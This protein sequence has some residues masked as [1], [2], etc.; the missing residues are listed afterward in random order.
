MTFFLKAVFLLL[1]SHILKMLRTV[2]IINSYI[3]NPMKAYWFS[4]G[5]GYFVDFFF[6]FR[7]SDITRTFI[8]SRKTQTPWSLSL[9]LAI[10]ERIFDLVIILIILFFFHIKSPINLCLTIIGIFIFI[11][12][13]YKILRNLY[14]YIGSVF[15]DCIKNFLFSVYWAIC[16]L[17]KKILYNPHVMSV[18]LL[19]TI[20]IWLFYVWSLMI[21]SEI[22]TDISTIELISYQFTTLNSAGIWTARKIFHSYSNMYFFYLLIPALFAIIIG[23]KSEKNK[24]TEVI[25]NII[26]FMSFD[27][28]LK[29]V[30]D[31]MKNNF[32]QNDEMYY[33]MTY[34]ACRVKDLSAASGAKTYLMIDKGKKFIRKIALGVYAEKLKMQFEWLQANKKLPLPAILQKNESDTLFSYDMEYFAEGQ[35]FFTTIHQLS[36]VESCEVLKNILENLNQ[37]YSSIAHHGKQEVVKKY[38]DL[39]LWKNITIVDQDPIIQQFKDSH[40]LYANGI[41]VPNILYFA[42][43]LENYAL[44]NLSQFPQQWIHG[45]LTIENILVDLDKNYILIDPSPAFIDIFAEYAKLFQ[46][47]HAHYEHV[48]LTP[49]W[50]VSQNSITYAQYGT[51]KYYDLFLFLKRYILEKYGI[52]GLKAVFF[53]E[54]VCHLRTLRYMV[55]L[56]QPRAIL[57][58]ALSGLAL[59][60]WN[61]LGGNN[62]Y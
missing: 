31:F 52:E 43:Q 61:D 49:T 62:E 1:L 57:M 28:S 29:F 13:P 23:M 8:F 47:L 11:L 38:L 60:E 58:L 10:I 12:C 33:R 26:P 37:H 32:S 20:L 48:K 36:N 18:F 45:D 7:I 22:F 9:A 46:S 39:Y 5:V 16:Q 55:S 54:A 40:F 56:K 42:D 17:R 34:N 2:F 21:L 25:L 44:E 14:F 24:S 35:K 50:N 59:K 19:I 41:K 53:Y 4:L 15:N 6:P 51:I 27:D 3:K 30:V